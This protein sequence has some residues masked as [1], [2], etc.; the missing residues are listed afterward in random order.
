MRCDEGNMSETIIWTLLPNG[1]VEAGESHGIK[2]GDLRVT[3]FISP[4]LESPSDTTL[5][6]FADWKDWPN[7]LGRL[8][9][10]L[11]LTF[12]GQNAPSILDPGSSAASSS[13]WKAIFLASTFVRGTQPE[14]S[15]T[16]RER[17]ARALFQDLHESFIVSNPATSIL[18]LVQ[19]TYQNIIS[20][21]PDLLP[22]FFNSRG[23]AALA[24]RL[25]QALGINPPTPNSQT[26]NFGAGSFYPDG[27]ATVLY[28]LPSGFPAIPPG[29][30]VTITGIL[31]SGY[32]GGYAVL[33]TTAETKRGTG[34][35]VVSLPSNPG[36][37]IPVVSPKGSTRERRGQLRPR[38]KRGGRK[39][40]AGHPRPSQHCL[41][42]SENGRHAYLSGRHYHRVGSQAGGV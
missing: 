38:S 22:D 2:E 10:N 42:V 21:T 19:T 37:F 8:L 29:A 23:D 24:L 20:M 1:L 35:V 32:N 30:A 31:P 40:V 33:S 3:V 6:T 16:P 41:P 27:K 18:P 28:T 17:L 5:A 36:P 15:D 13:W 12:N 4:R 26:A 7:R 11:K 25:Q 9:P 34:A 39:L 14:P